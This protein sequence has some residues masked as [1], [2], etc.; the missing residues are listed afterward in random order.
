MISKV[1]IVSLIALANIA[2]SEIWI[3][4][5]ALPVGNYYFGLASYNNLLYA[6]GGND[7]SKTISN[8]YCYNGTI[9]LE[10]NP[11]P[12]ACYGLGL[13]T[14]NDLLYAVGGYDGSKAM[15]NVYCYNGTN[16]LE[17]KS[18]PV[19]RR[20]LSVATYNNLLYAVGGV[21]NSGIT[22]SNVYCYNGTNWV[23]ISPLPAVRSRLGLA[24]CNNLLYAVGGADGTTAKS[25]VYCYNGTA[26]METNSL[27]ATRY[28]LGLAT[29]NNRLYAVAGVDAGVAKSNVY[30][31][32]G[33]AWV[34]TNSLPAA[35]YGLG[36]VTHSDLLYAVGGWNSGIKSNVYCYTAPQLLSASIF[37]TNL[38]QTYNGSAR[39][40]RG[41]TTPAGLTYD[42]TYDGYSWAPTNVGSYAITGIITSAGY[43]GTNTG[44][45]VV[46]QAAATVTLASLA[47]TY[48]GSARSA[49]A[50]T[51]PEGLA[52]N[53]T[54]DGSPFAPTNAGSYTV[55]G[56]VVDANYTGATTNT[57]VIAQAS[58]TITFPAI[59]TQVV[60]NVLALEGSA[61]SGFPVTYEV[62][63][64]PAQL[65]GSQLAFT[66]RGV[67]S[68]VASQA[69]NGNFASA[70][71]A[72]NTFNV[73]GFFDLT[74]N[75]I[76]SGSLPAAGV[77]SVLEGT[78]IT[79][80][81]LWT[82]TLNTTQYVCQGWTLLG[83]EPAGGATN[84]L[85]L[86]ITNT[87]ML[88]WLWATNYWLTAQALTGG[89]VDVT[90]GWFAAGSNATLT[91][92][93]LPYFHFTNWSGVFTSAVNPLV[94]VMDEPKSMT[95]N[96][97]AALTVTNHI[98]HWWLAQHGLTNDFEL[99]AQSDVDGDGVPNWAE[100]VAGTNPT[101]GASVFKM[102][103]S[104]TLLGTNYYEVIST[105]RGSQVL[106]NRVYE[107]TG[108]VW[109]WQ[110]A[111]GRYY[112]IEGVPQLYGDTWRPVPGGTNLF[113][114]GTI[115]FTNLF[116]N[117]TNQYE[118]FRIRARRE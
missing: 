84:Y 83:M 81:A 78:V 63:A 21:D 24:T 114:A 112:D 4:T 9:W 53:F 54:Y 29:R 38:N 42:I 109:C 12:V 66:N 77:Y 41:T 97:A 32:N 55:T 1:F 34:E 28:A 111:P 116:N 72:T 87:V 2:Y 37:F 69:G 98:P 115:T 106:T 8:V 60:T 48:T 16:W 58:Q 45:L 13:A 113:G 39:T 22:K 104:E 31:Y 76:A 64:G 5:N 79:N 59:A 17:T 82:N 70:A 56:T 36:L 96:F 110:S 75:T 27:P 65:S 35:R 7:G 90:N 3:Q 26:W 30:C 99:D 14:Y 19:S 100:Y 73:L 117:R 105:N 46:N 47:Q 6:V 67:V 23:E 50:T 57:L 102:L 15:S 33:T 44:T 85:E 52:V 62:L 95:A 40:V 49:T 51:T 103:R 20:Y 91:A 43:F 80:A 89:S 11:L 25:N 108:Q 68:I 94:L 61:S 18:L 88:T 118:F 101:N 107:V 93:A 86:T 92:T 74:V 10:T 71:P